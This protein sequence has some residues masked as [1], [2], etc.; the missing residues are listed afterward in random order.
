M[1]EIEEV[2]LTVGIERGV[3][4]RKVHNIKKKRD[5]VRQREETDFEHVLKRRLLHFG[6]ITSPSEYSAS[7]VSYALFL[8]TRVHAYLDL[9]LPP[10]IY[11]LPN[12]IS[13][14]TC[15]PSFMSYTNTE[16]GPRTDCTLLSC[17]IKISI[18]LIQ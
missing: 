15:I 9:Y 7:I 18:Q 4:T 13:E 2:V 1:C 11:P 16:I 3:G 14:R 8:Y 10:L 12:R 6:Q 17:D 5:R